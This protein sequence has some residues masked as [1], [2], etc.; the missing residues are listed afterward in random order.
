MISKDLKR[1]LLF[2]SSTILNAL[3]LLISCLQIVAQ[4]I[5][6][7]HTNG[8]L[9]L[10]IFMS[11]GLVHVLDDYCSRWKDQKDSALQALSKELHM[12][13]SFSMNTSFTSL[14]TVQDI[15]QNGKTDEHHK[16][17]F[18]HLNKADN[19]FRYGVSH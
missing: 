17:P 11:T 6:M 7:V 19:C 9:L 14:N 4:W 18:Q 5:S 10:G 16:T 15:Q 13:L 2:N 3:S 8:V 12:P 1:S